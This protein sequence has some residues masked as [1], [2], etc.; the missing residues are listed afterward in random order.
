MVLWMIRS[1]LR[2][3]F[4]RTSC[5]PPSLG[6]GEQ[7]CVTSL[8]CK[9]PYADIDQENAWATFSLALS[10]AIVF[11]SASTVLHSYVGFLRVLTNVIFSI[12]RASGVSLNFFDAQKWL[13]HRQQRFSAFRHLFIWSSRKFY[14]Q[15]GEDQLKCTFVSSLQES[16][17]KWI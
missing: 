2:N 5:T 6:F 7:Q 16:T 13:I 4:K 12:V 10:G 3:Q 15:Q 17:G 1:G 11:F 14:W 9:Q 8:V